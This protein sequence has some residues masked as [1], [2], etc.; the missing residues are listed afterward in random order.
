MGEMKKIDY[1]NNTETTLQFPGNGIY[2]TG[3]RILWKNASGDR[4]NRLVFPFI[5]NGL[6]GIG[7]YWNP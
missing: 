7:E 5:Q 3:K 6:M 2:C 1:I 4:P